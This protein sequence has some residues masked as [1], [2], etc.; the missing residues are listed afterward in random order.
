MSFCFA[1]GGRAL[2]Y[3]LYSVD[4]QALRLHSLRVSSSNLLPRCQ[5]QLPVEAQLQVG[6]NAHWQPPCGKAAV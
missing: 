2:V 4:A 6:A 1:R 5:A 3:I